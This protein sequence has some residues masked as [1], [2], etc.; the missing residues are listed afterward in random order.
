MTDKKKVYLVDDDVVF[1]Q[2]V[3]INLELSREYEVITFHTGEDLIAHIKTTQ[4]YPEVFVLDY[5]LNSVDENA[6]N[7][8]K[9]LEILRKE[10]KPKNGNI[11]AIILSGTGEV[12]DAVNL[13]KKGAKDYI[14]KEGNYLDSLKSS[15]RNIIELK[16]IRQEK[17]MYKDQATNLK[18]RLFLTMGIG[19]VVIAAIAI[20]FLTFYGK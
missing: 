16:Q 11:Y 6:Q 5:I 15:I 12:K 1:A 13:L 3:K 18:K 19:A 8:D 20:Y 10:Y 17:E 9:I 7:G 14:I 4:E 2:G